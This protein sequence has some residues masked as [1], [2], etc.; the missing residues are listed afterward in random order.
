MFNLCCAVL[1]VFVKFGFPELEILVVEM[2]ASLS[3][4]LQLNTTCFAMLNASKNTS[5]ELSSNSF[6][7]P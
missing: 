3:N 2:F 4:I 7:K 6:E 5:E 1:L